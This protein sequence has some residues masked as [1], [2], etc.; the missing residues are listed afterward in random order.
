MGEAS[1]AGV[2]DVN[3][4]F[5][6]PGAI[7]GIN[8]AEASFSYSSWIAD[9]KALYGAAGFNLDGIATFVVNY[10]SLDYGNMPGGGVISS[11]GNIDT[12]TGKLFSRGDLVVGVR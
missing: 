7:T 8:N 9:L 1:I 2:Q 6:N 11:T 10:M 3:S 12:R 5:W 4:I